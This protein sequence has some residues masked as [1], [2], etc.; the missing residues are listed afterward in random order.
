MGAS[1]EVLGSAFGLPGGKN[2][3]IAGA[4]GGIFS[5]LQPGV[6]IKKNEVGVRTRWGD[7]KRRNWWLPRKLG[8][9]GVPYGTLNTGLHA[10][11]THSIKRIKTVDWTSA[12]HPLRIES[13]EQRQLDVL[14]FVTWGVNPDDDNPEKAF[15]KLDSPQELENAIGAMSVRGLREVTNKKPEVFINDNDTVESKVIEN[16]NGRLLDRWGVEIRLLHLATVTP[17]IGQMI[18]ESSTAQALSMMAAVF[19]N[20]NGG[21]QGLGDL[22]EGHGGLQVT[23]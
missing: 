13:E 12:L 16:Y 17:S 7:T 18:R 4:V 1:S 19:S 9:V 20:G 10:T 23:Q 15:F 22:P 21:S 2:L 3:L 14:A 5:V 6:V 8:R 11:P